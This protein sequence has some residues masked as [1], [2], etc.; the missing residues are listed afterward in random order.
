MKRSTITIKEIVEDRRK[1]RADAAR[2]EAQQTAAAEAAA[3]TEM[4]ERPDSERGVEKTAASSPQ[5]DDFFRMAPTTPAPG[6]AAAQ[7]PAAMQQCLFPE[8]VPPFAEFQRL[9]SLQK[10]QSCS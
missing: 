7:E 6:A 4:G 8:E 1:R 2:T 5:P 9:H 3:A 10:P